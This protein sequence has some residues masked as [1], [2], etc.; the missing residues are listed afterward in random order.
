MK[1][2]ALPVLSVLLAGVLWGIIGIFIK[3]LSAAGLTAMQICFVRLL[4]AAPL[5]FFSTLIIYPKKLFFHLRDIWIFLGTGILSVVVFNYCYFYTVIHSEASVAVVLLY[6][7]PIFV[8]LLSVLL[9]KEKVSPEK[10]IALA[11]TFIGCLL[12]SGV[13]GGGAEVKP[14]VAFVGLASGFFYALYT[15]F[16]AFGLKKYDTM[17]VTTYT[18]VIAFLAELP[19]ADVG[20]LFSIVN[21]TP[22]LWIWCVAISVLST[23]LPFF[24][25]TWGLKKVEPSRSAMLVAVEPLVGCL[26]GMIFYGES[27]SFV[28]ILGILFVLGAILLVSI[29]KRTKKAPVPCEVQLPCPREDEGREALLI[30]R[31]EDHENR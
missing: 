22:S 14:F 11:M 6:T 16:G 13:T 30:P 3:K 12:V 23:V 9:F 26:V 4:F 15:I 17:T 29:P 31:N 5:F 19:I 25:Y 2:S 20:S 8:M 10:I 28:K 1:K 7:S 24:F 18:F 27:H 21:A